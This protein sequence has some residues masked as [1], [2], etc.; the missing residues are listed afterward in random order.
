MRTKNRGY[1]IDLFLQDYGYKGYYVECIYIFDRYEN[2]Y[3]V[4]MWLCHNQFEDRFKIDSQK[5]SDT[6]I[7]CE[8]DE[9]RDHLISI[10]EKMCEDRSIDKYI[11][12]F[13]FTTK[14]FDYG[15]EYYMSEDNHAE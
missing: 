15:C 4:D 1:A 13:E 10:M 11:E 2:K 5:M 14:C 6:F 8:R 3:K 9:V 7:E 12:R